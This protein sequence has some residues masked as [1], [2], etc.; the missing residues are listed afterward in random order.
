M[1]SSLREILSWVKEVPTFLKRLGLRFSTAVVVRLPSGPPKPV[2]T[3]FLPRLD[4]AVIS[5][6]QK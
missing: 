2:L 1:Q 4:N 5:P 3:L 6:S